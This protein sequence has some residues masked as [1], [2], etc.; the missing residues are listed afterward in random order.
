MLLPP[1]LGVKPMPFGVQVTDAVASGLVGHAADEA[2]HMAE[3]S[4]GVLG[5][6]SSGLAYNDRASRVLTAATLQ[7][8]VEST[9]DSPVTGMFLRV[10]A[11]SCL[12]RLFVV[13]SHRLCTFLS[14]VLS[15]LA[16]RYAQGTL[17]DVS[18][19]CSQARNT[20]TSPRG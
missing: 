16:R 11:G 3:V 12:T 8:V 6:V 17:V 1:R 13:Y 10:I 4:R 14:S 15:S 20:P 19:S 5:A 9:I 2:L 18:R 7:L